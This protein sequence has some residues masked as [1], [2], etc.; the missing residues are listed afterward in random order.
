VERSGLSVAEASKALTM[1]QLHG[2]IKA[3]KGMMYI[4]L[5]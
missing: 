3:V 4:K 5:K 1:M 2:V